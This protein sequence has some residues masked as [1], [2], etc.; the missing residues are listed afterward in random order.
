MFL[1]SEHGVVFNK[2]MTELIEYP[3]C[4][5][6]AYAIPAGIVKIWP[7]AFFGCHALTEV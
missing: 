6:G 5:V 2:D 3:G 4:R 1:L 7:H